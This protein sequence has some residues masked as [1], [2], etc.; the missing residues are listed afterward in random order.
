MHS[1]SILGVSTQIMAR[2]VR[3]AGSSTTAVGLSAARPKHVLQ[4]MQLHDLLT[5]ELMYGVLRLQ[6]GRNSLDTY[7]VRGRAALEFPAIP[8]VHAVNTSRFEPFLVAAVQQALQEDLCEFSRRA[9][10][11]PPSHDASKS[12]HERDSNGSF[13]GSQVCRQHILGEPRTAEEADQLAEPEQEVAASVSSAAAF[14]PSSSFGSASG[15]APGSVQSVGTQAS[16]STLCQIF[17]D[18]AKGVGTSADAAS[19]EAAKTGGGGA[20]GSGGGDIGRRQPYGTIAF[21]GN[22]PLN[23]AEDRSRVARADLIV[24]FNWMHHRLAGEGVDVWVVTHHPGSPERWGGFDDLDPAELAE[25]LGQAPLLVFLGGPPSDA[26]WTLRRHAALLPGGIRALHVTTAEYHRQFAVA[27][28]RV[29]DVPQERTPTSGFTLIAAALACTPAG[30]GL[31]LF[32]F[33]WSPKLAERHPK[34]SE[35]AVVK[36]A[37][38]RRWVQLHFSPCTALRSCGRR[39]E[40]WCR[41]R[42]SA[43]AYPAVARED[44]LTHVV[45][46]AVDLPALVHLAYPLGDFSRLSPPADVSQMSSKIRDA[47]DGS[48]KSDSST[49]SGS[50]SSGGSGLTTGSGSAKGADGH[51]AALTSSRHSQ[52][53]VARGLPEPAASSV[54]GVVVPGEVFGAEPAT[55]AAGGSSQLEA[56]QWRRAFMRQRRRWWLRRR[57]IEKTALCTAVRGK[58]GE[59]GAIAIVGNGPLSPADRAAINGSTTVV[60]LNMANNWAA[61]ERTDVWVARH[62]GRRPAAFYGFDVEAA[63]MTDGEVNALY[64]GARAVV[65]MGGNASSAEAMLGRY[66]HLPADRLLHVTLDS[67]LHRYDALYREA[68]PSSRNATTKLAVS[69]TTGFAVAVAAVACAP[70]GAVNLYGFNWSPQH[71][72][73][74]DPPGERRVLLGMRAAR[75]LHIHMPPCHGLRACVKRQEATCRASRPQCW[76]APTAYLRAA[77]AALLRRSPSL[78]P[79][80]SASAAAAAEAEAPSASDGIMAGSSTGRRYSVPAYDA[81][82]MAFLCRVLRLSTPQRSAPRR[83][84]WQR[85]RWQRTGAPVVALFGGGALSRAETSVVRRAVL[86]LRFDSSDPRLLLGRSSVW[87]P[88]FERNATGPSG[89]FRGVHAAA[90]DGG[91]ALKAA[92]EAVAFWGGLHHNVQEAIQA[93][94]LKL[95]SEPEVARVVS[96]GAGSALERLL[97]GASAELAGSAEIGVVAVALACTRGGRQ[98]RIEM[99]G[100]QNHPR[101]QELQ[102]AMV[103]LTQAGGI[104]DMS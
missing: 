31:H 13:S 68:V 100:F 95:E 17:A 69:P 21:V 47:D 59:P 93:M 57:A 18:P 75:L 63:T 42:T 41:A 40:H 73:R 51:G 54:S 64:L 82:E 55:G 90:R 50:N 85:L 97:K 38:A 8:A 76:V 96:D 94:G 81:A 91:A 2:G 6:F 89:V 39:D 101:R 86:V 56:K 104:T 22:A 11:P 28:R 84:L 66:P 92:T 25:V 15:T 71:W 7:D 98:P 20:G 77:V 88:T 58:A 49:S 16:P 23:E 78:S 36:E 70:Q 12:E 72:G 33:N 43:C 44:L 52:D 4:T 60:R 14:G 35:H 32:G 29:K 1:H 61:G 99:I 79:S 48:N 3:N 45:T 67:F 19:S 65:L 5:S 24:R 9:M 103:A 102:A 53:M 74:H 83:T 34:W 62:C 10:A 30:T 46:P 80:P 37:A 26:A 87:V 27:F